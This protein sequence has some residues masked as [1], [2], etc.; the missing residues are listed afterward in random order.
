[1]NANTNHETMPACCCRL[2]T[3]YQYFIKPSKFTGNGNDLDCLQGCG[4]DLNEVVRQL[5]GLDRPWPL[6]N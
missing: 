2:M 5:P 4:A 1:M 6:V 3:H